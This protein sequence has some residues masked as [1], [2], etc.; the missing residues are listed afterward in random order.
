MSGSVVCAVA[1]SPAVTVGGGESV[2]KGS[3]SGSDDGSMSV[4]S[5]C[6]GSWCV[7]SWCVGSRGVSVVGRGGVHSGSVSSVHCRSVTSV[8]GVGHLVG[9]SV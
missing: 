7:G 5:G 8:D 1:V 4:G 3:V 2:A 6:V 9:V